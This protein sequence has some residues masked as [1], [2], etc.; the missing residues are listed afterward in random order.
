MFQK[1]N[2]PEVCVVPTEPPADTKPKCEFVP[3]SESECPSDFPSMKKLKYCGLNT[4][5]GELCN[6]MGIVDKD[7]RLR[8]CL[9]FF[10][11]LRYT[12]EPPEPLY[13]RLKSGKECKSKD[14]FLDK[15]PTVEACA[16]AVREYDSSAKFFIYGIRK[17]AYKKCYVELTKSRNC[18]EGW[19]T[20]DYDFYELSHKND[21]WENG[22]IDYYI[23]TWSEDREGLYKYVITRPGESGSVEACKALCVMENGC[24]SITYDTSSDDRTYCW[25]I[26]LTQEEAKQ[27]KQWKWGKNRIHY[28]M[29]QSCAATQVPNSGHS[30]A[31]SIT[32]YEGDKVSVKCNRGY[33]GSGV[34]T[35]GSN[36]RFNLVKCVKLKTISCTRMKIRQS[37]PTKGEFT[38]GRAWN[39]Q[40]CAEVCESLGQVGCCE[41]QTDHR[42][43]VFNP[44]ARWPDEGDTILRYGAFCRRIR[45][46][47]S[48]SLFEES[49]ETPQAYSA[50]F[51]QSF[52]PT[53]QFIL[54]AIGALGLIYGAFKL[55]CHKNTYNPVKNH[56]EI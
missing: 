22:V 18:P 51:S 53:I 41:Y 35:C 47:E 40:Q 10:D 48:V 54:A 49:P 26:P 39:S 4:K 14:K 15:F 23:N 55:S 16:K 44:K 21:G 45:A 20:D 8:N 24:K 1:N 5:D 28:D 29:K 19:E 31:G 13:S 43:C 7:K 33:E 30:K 32:G 11:V 25:L 42:R 56:A 12:C 6:G 17:G 36:G 2:R 37:C 3:V 27:K 34:A 38:A 52:S 46:E 50:M 9:R